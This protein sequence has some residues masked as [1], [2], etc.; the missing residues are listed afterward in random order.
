MNRDELIEK[1]RHNQ[2]LVTDEGDPNQFDF[3]NTN[4]VNF[5]I[6]LPDYL[7]EL[8]RVPGGYLD[9]DD[10]EEKEIQF[11]GTIDDLISKTIS[12]AAYY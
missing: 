12:R 5:T 3:R 1:L 10:W 11:D 8:L 6:Y 4:G 9:P 2:Y 7:V